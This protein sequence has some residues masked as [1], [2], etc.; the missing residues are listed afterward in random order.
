MFEIRPSDERYEKIKTMVV[1]T[2][3]KYK[4]SC[5]PVNGYEIAKKMEIKIVFYSSLEKKK[6]IAAAKISLDGFSLY[7]NGE[8]TIFLNDIEN[9]YRR[10]NN[11]LL[12][13]IGHIVLDHTEDSELADKE[14]NFFAKYA[15]VP[16][17]LVYKWNLTTANEIKERF[18]VSQQAAEYALDYYHKWYYHSGIIKPYEIEL[19]K[20]FGFDLEVSGG[21][22]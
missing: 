6:L 19:A 15:L 5:V 8:W 1:D 13:E 12:H 11:T 20:L 9:D 2:F 22:F 16:P 3:K 7:N 17:I 21:D 14:A 10:Q 18:E 4:I